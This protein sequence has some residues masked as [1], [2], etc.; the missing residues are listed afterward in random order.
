MPNKKIKILERIKNDKN[1]Q[2]NLLIFSITVGI[3][4]LSLGVYLVGSHIPF[5]S[6]ILTTGS[7]IFY[8]SIILFVFCFA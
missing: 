6:T 3:L 4:L 1:F 2:E 8:V 5:G 7:G